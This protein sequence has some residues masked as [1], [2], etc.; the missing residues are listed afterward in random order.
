MNS[1]ILSTVARILQPL[2]LLFALFVLFRGHNEPGGGFIAGLVA[3]ASFSLF[4]FA[5]S[6][7]AAREALRVSPRQLIA[8][9]LLLAIASALFPLLLGRAF[10]TGVWGKTVFPI[11]GKLGT[12]LF[13]DIGVFFVVVGVVMIIVFTL[14]EEE[15][16]Q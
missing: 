16:P 11:V 15:S 8:S 10:M 2:L 12:P 9:G 7:R 14:F 13:F 4:V 3:A 5:E 6:A 1:L